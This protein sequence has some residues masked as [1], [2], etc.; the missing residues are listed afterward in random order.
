MPF[1]DD[2]IRSTSQQIRPSDASDISSQVEDGGT[3]VAFAA[4]P[5][6]PQPQPEWAEVALARPEGYAASEAWRAW[7]DAPVTEVCQEGGRTVLVAVDDH[8]V[9]DVPALVACLGS[10]TAAAR[11][12]GEGAPLEI[13]SAGATATLRVDG[14]RVWNAFG[15]WSAPCL[16]GVL[17]VAIG[18][19]DGLGLVLE[20][21]DVPCLAALAP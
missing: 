7:L 4:R 21:G 1:S 3:S 8:P 9:A 5:A 6:E 11:P 10:G 16:P 13:R 2:T 20:D 18:D 12:A 19:G 14:E 15:A 17:A